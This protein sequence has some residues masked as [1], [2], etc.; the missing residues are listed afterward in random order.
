ME[1]LNI[2]VDLDAIFEMQINEH[3]CYNPGLLLPFCQRLMGLNHQ[4]VELFVFSMHDPSIS[5]IVFDSLSYYGLNINQ[6]IFTGGESTVSYLHALEV[7]LYLSFDE[8]GIR[9]MKESGIL[10]GLLTR[11]GYKETLS[12]IFDHRLFLDEITYPGLGKWLPLIGYLQQQKY[13]ISVELMTTRTCSV[14]RLVLELFKESNCKI[15]AMCFI[16]SGKGED[17]IEL[18]SPTV[19]FSACSQEALKPLPNAECILNIAF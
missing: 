9:Q 8:K 14:D 17:L 3:N 1:R 6:L 7:E 18:Y 4:V 10:S 11:Q 2:G 19:Y 13:P 5:S 15:N 12:F 16:A